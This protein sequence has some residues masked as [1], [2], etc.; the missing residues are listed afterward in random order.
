MS[1]RKLKLNPDKTNFLLIGSEVQR[2]KILKCFP[3]RLLAQEVTP[4][5]S[6][7]NIGVIFDS[8]LNFKIQGVPCSL[9]QVT[10]C[11]NPG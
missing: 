8:A 3:T 9:H 4:S 10:P 5:Q 1:S 11:Y 7:R 2:K 6:A